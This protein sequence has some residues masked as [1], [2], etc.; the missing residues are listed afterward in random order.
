MR[1]TLKQL[2][3]FIAAGETL[4]VTRASEQLNISQPSVS[5]AIAHLEAELQVQLFIRRQAQGLLLTEAGKTLLRTAR[6]AMGAAGAVYDVARDMRELIEGAL[7]VGTFLSLAPLIAPELW[8]GFSRRY[9]KVQMTM[10]E[11]SM[12]DLIEALRDA[13]V[14]LA[15]TWGVDVPSDITFIELSRMPPCAILPTAHRL[16]RQGTVRLAD[17]VEEPFVL[18]D[19]PG[20][21]EYF[22]GL[23]QRLGIAPRIVTRTVSTA[24]LR[25]YVAAGIGYG[26][27]ATRP[28]NQ[29]AENGLPLAYVPLEDVK[30]DVAFGIARLTDLRPSRV[31]GAFIDH[32]LEVMAD[33]RLPGTAWPTNTARDQKS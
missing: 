23:F 24:A 11:G 10:S 3:Y 1:F 15:L 19:L 16:A 30:E 33:G 21:R 32:C 9:D 18:V 29:A 12:P 8:A 13:R 28:C 4:S 14:E 20:T 2:S 31:V 26:L 5:A 6:E 17:L 7:H 27:T 25:S 22:L